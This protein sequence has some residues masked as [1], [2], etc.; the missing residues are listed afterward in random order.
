MQVRLKHHK[1]IG[2]A[3][4]SIGVMENVVLFVLLIKYL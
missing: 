3:V 1:Q 2:E 4:D